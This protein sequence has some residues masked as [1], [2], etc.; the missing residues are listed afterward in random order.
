MYV[1]LEVLDSFILRAVFV[2]LLSS[3]SF[4]A[5]FR[6]VPIRYGLLFQLALQCCE[7]KEMLWLMTVGFCWVLLG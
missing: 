5:S 6:L 2:I 3:L 4:I 1:R 7:I